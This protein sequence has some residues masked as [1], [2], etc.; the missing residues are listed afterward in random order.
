MLKQVSS[1]LYKGD[2][3]QEP[4][5][6]SVRTVLREGY[7]GI[8]YSALP[9]SILVLNY[10]DLNRNPGPNTW[11]V[12][13]QDVPKGVKAARSETGGT[14]EWM[15]SSCGPIKYTLLGCNFLV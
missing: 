12:E 4:Y 15:A 1:S 3:G 10:M 7:S 14:V 9:Y 13:A 8:H 5:T 11:R 6:R 2:F